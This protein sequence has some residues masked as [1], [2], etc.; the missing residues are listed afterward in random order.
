MDDR[1]LILAAIKRDREV[2][3]KEIERLERS[4]SF[5]SISVTKNNEIVIQT[6]SGEFVSNPLNI[7]VPSDGKDG[8]NGVSIQSVEQD[9]DSLVIK[10]DNG[11]SSDPIQLPKPDN[12]V[13][14]ADGVSV[15][16]IVQDGFK[17]VVTLSDD[18]Q[19]QFDMPQPEQPKDPENGS[20]G[21]SVEDIQLDGDDIVITLSDGTAKRIP[22]PQ[23]KTVVEKEPITYHTETVIE[24]PVERV[25]Q[26]SGEDFNVSELRES[27]LDEIADEFERLT[28]GF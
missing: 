27:V 16:D 8:E 4:F 20:D 1:L 6:P 14:G 10:Y 22:A 12:G 18:R 28:S 19:F 2:L 24:K 17:M 7:S 3:E 9:G 21:V 11:E 13:N 23:N 25:V 26:N 5:S 15:Q